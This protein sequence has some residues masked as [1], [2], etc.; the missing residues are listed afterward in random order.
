[1][2]HDKNKV[3][4]AVR[5]TGISA[6]NGEYIAFLDDEWTENKFEL[7]MK[8]MT[9]EYAA[10]VYFDHLYINASGNDEYKKPFL[11]CIVMDNDFERFLCFTQLH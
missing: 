4:C 3:A 1:M 10:M 2:V 5:N 8:K 6:E 7:Q 11:E 9:E